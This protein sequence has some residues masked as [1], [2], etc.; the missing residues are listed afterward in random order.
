MSGP[1]L[2]RPPSSVSPEKKKQAK[3]DEKIRNSIEGKFGQ[4][5]RRF[6]LSRVMAKLSHT[7]ETAI[8]IT[9]LVLNL[10]T[11]LR[12]VFFGFF[13]SFFANYSFFRCFDYQK[14]SKDRLPTISTYLS[15]NLIPS[16]IRAFAIANLFSKP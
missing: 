5:K 9:F 14:L 11:W 6:S 12:Q 3:E 2:G 4:A 10:S 13:V 16:L 15:D 7:S 8:A 1:P